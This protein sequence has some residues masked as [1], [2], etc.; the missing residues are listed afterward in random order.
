MISKRTLTKF[1]KYKMYLSD[2]Y[3]I[4]GASIKHFFSKILRHDIFMSY[5]SELQRICKTF[6]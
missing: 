1:Y 6:L 3:Q 4:S 2:K 5:V